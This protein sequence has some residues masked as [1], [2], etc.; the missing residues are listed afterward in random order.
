MKTREDGKRLLIVVL[1][2]IGSDFR[3]GE[4]KGANGDASSE[5]VALVLV[6]DAG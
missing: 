1:E 5:R 4:M 2:F 3:N 6:W